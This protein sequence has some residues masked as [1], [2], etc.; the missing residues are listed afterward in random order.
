MEDKFAVERR[1]C[2]DQSDNKWI[3]SKW[4]KGLNVET[5]NIIAGDVSIVLYYTVLCCY[6]KIWGHIGPHPRFINYF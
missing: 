1:A 4:T 6:F 2:V 3:K 5:V